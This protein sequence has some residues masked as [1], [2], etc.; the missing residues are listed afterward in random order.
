MAKVLGDIAGVVLPILGA[1]FGQIA[2]NVKVAMGIVMAMIQPVI[3]TIGRLQSALDAL[4]NKHTNATGGSGG[5][6]FSGGGSGGSKAFASGGSYAAGQPRLVG[7]NGPE[8]DI[9]NHSGTIIPNGALG[10]TVINI[11]LDRGVFID[12]PSVEV[13]TRNIVQRLRLKGIY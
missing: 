10:G 11:N 8:L 2:D 12:G 4:L 3:D 1:A 5:Q 6:V 9:P 13:L 7:E